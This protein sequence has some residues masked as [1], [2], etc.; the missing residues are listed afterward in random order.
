LQ[1]ILY[2][3]LITTNFI[4]N[5]HEFYN[6]I[7][8]NYPEKNTYQLRFLETIIEKKNLQIFLTNLQK[9]NYVI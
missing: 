5:I 1:N 4:E 7:G 6:F 8:N 9:R 2:E 3:T